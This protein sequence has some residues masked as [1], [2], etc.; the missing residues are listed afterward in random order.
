MHKPFLERLRVALSLPRLPRRVVSARMLAGGGRV[1]FEE[2]N[3][4]LLLRLPERGADEYDTVV[5]LKLGR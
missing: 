4:G 2:T 3:T 5:M 1:R